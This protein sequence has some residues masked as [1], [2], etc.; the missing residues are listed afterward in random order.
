MGRSVKREPPPNSVP[1]RERTGL[2]GG[3][4]VKGFRLGGALC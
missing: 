1:I 3:G 2:G 4:F